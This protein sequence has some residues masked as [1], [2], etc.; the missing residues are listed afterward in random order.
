MTSILTTDQYLTHHWIFSEGT[1]TDSVGTANMQQGSLT[2]FASDRFGCPN[3]A[4]NLNQG[5]T[6][7]PPGIY[8]DTPQFTISV[9]VYP[10]LMGW[11]SRVIDFGN[12]S[13]MDNIFLTQDSNSN[14]KPAL[15]I[16]DGSIFKGD[17]T[18]S[19]PLVLNKWHMLTATFD[20]THA[21][22][23]INGVFQE[24]SSFVHSLTTLIRTKNYI[25]K[26]DFTSIGYSSSLLDDLRFYNKSLT[27]GEITELMNLNNS[28]KL[29]VYNFDIW[30]DE[31]FIF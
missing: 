30:F 17:V 2:T 3:S 4:L 19:S 7:V 28:K 18:S 9:W 10:Q 6:F 25:G 1:M 16:F 14:Q 21:S 27:Q 8:F 11:W 5:Y 13:P 20:G 15:W 12:G 26:S 22:I 31:E 29:T 23:Y 24:S